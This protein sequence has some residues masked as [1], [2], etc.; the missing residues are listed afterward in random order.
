MTDELTN[1][2]IFD[3]SEEL[4]A[5]VTVDIPRKE[6]TMLSNKGTMKTVTCDD[7]DQFLSVIDLVRDTVKFDDVVYL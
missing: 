7:G 6:F 5:K 3:G 4:L 2:S 1:P